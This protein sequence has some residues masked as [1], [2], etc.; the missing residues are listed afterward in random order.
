MLSGASDGSVRPGSAKASLGQNFVSPLAMPELS[1]G[2]EI[3]ANIR[4]EPD[5]EK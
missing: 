2:Y 5:R 3:V 1:E 4:L